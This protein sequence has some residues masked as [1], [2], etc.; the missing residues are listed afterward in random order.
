MPNKR[1]IALLL[2]L[3]LSVVYSLISLVSEPELEAT[4][5]NPK[6]SISPNFA[7]EE[8]QFISSGLSKMKQHKQA[9]DI[10]TVSETTTTNVLTK[11]PISFSVVGIRIQSRDLDALT[12]IQFDSELY[13]YTLNELMLNTD[14]RLIGIELE[15]IIIEFN[16]TTHLVKLTPP[17]L[18]DTATAKKE[19]Y[20]TDMLA[21]TPKQ[22][23]SRPRIIEHMLNLIPTPYIADGMLIQPG[24]NP[25]LFAKAGFQEDDLLKKINGKSVTIEAQM[26]AIKLELKTAQTLEFQVMR[27]GRLITLYLDIP[28]EGL[29]LRLN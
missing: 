10:I 22:I 25:V 9:L 14:M 26:E 18:L 8:S 21:M 5:V 19:E 16:A 4:L 2:L 28:S 23:G 13:E 24:I 6:Q 29:Q 1:I 27:K 20:Y 17:N 12:L 15:H 7:R 11:L 3:S